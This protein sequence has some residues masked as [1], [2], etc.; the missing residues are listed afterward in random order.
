MATIP[1]RKGLRVDPKLPSLEDRRWIGNI[2][3]INNSLNGRIVIDEDIKKDG[4]H[5][6]GRWV[7]GGLPV[8]KDGDN[9]KIF[10]AT[11]KGAGKKVDGFVI[12]PGEIKDLGAEEYFPHYHSGIV[13]S[14]I[15]YA[16]YLPVEVTEADLAVNSNIT[17]VKGNE[18]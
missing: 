11:A 9:Y 15:V 10:T 5:R 3:T 6:V 1:T 4:P 13:V 12:S 14:G 7:K 17:L 8:Y 2:A 16:I 18:A